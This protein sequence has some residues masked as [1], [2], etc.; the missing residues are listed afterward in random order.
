MTLTV[1][2]KAYNADSYGSN[3][4]GYIGPTKTASTK[5]DLVLRRTAAKP[6]STFS[7]VARAQAKLTRTMTLTGAKTPSW[8]G[9]F[10][11]Q[12]SIPVGFAAADVDAMCADIGAYVASADFK[13]LLKTQKISY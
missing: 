7:G 9:I 10:D 1:N 13:N 5:D 3:S 12:A 6:T 4:V 2:A 11:I 8:E